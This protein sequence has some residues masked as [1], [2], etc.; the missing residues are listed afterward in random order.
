MIVLSLKECFCLAR[1]YHSSFVDRGY[2]IMSV[3]SCGTVLQHHCDCHSAFVASGG[4]RS[5]LGRYMSMVKSCL[6]P[7]VQCPRG[8]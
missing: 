1:D 6:L 2:A 4:R 8:C 7:D 5:W 3:L